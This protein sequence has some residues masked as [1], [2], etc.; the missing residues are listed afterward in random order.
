MNEQ[1]NAM[2]NK[3]KVMEEEEEKKKIESNEMKRK[4]QHAATCSRT[5]SRRRLRMCP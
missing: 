5:I 2:R 1:L 4:S 3:I